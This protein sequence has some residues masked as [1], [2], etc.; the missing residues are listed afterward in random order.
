MRGGPAIDKQEVTYRLLDERQPSP[1]PCDAPHPVPGG[2]PIGGPEIDGAFIPL[3]RRSHLGVLVSGKTSYVG[4]F[5][6]VE[7]RYE[8]P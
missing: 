5:D 3:R 4:K 1:F 6:S 2:A 7:L 8:H